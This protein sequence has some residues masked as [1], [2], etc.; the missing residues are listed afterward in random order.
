MS[1]MAL[2]VLGV[3]VV[4]YTDQR[5]GPFYLAGLLSGEPLV[6]AQSYLSIIALLVA[7][8][9]ATTRGLCRPDP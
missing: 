8:I 6:L 1:S 5:I 2:L 7:V 3:M 9:R 4:S